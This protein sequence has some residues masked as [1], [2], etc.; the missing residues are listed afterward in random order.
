MTRLNVRRMLTK[1]IL[2][3]ILPVTLCICIDLLFDLM[4]LLTIVSSIICIPLASV[5]VIKTTLAEFDEVIQRVAPVE[6][7]ESS[8]SSH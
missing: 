7:G 3:L 1:L 5:V 2:L 4:P 6:S 8:S